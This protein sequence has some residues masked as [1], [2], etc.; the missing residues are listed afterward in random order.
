[1]FTQECKLAAI[2]N[3]NTLNI[4]KFFFFFFLNFTHIIEH[5]ENKFLSN[6]LT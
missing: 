5:S 1:M 3:Y 4:N 6:F 2:M